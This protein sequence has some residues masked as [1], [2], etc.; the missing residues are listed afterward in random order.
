[1]GLELVLGHTGTRLTKQEVSLSFYS[2]S[3]PIHLALPQLS[4]WTYVSPLTPAHLSAVRERES[5]SI[6]IPPAVYVT[7]LVVD[8]NQGWQ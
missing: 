4:S 7:L 1:M 3:P 8:P 5:D 6:S 2:V